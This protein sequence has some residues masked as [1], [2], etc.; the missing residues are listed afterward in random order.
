MQRK[1][2]LRAS[3]ATLCCEENKGLELSTPT[4]ADY[5]IPAVNNGGD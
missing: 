4:L 2:K 1:H 5:F 3:T